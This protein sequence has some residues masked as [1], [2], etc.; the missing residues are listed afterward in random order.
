MAIGAPLGGI[1]TQYAGWQLMIYVCI[2]IALIGFVISW[3]AIPKEERLQSKEKFDYIGSFTFTASIILIM[4]FLTAGSS[5]GWGA[6]NTS[7][8][9]NG[10]L[11]SLEIFLIVEK[12]TQNAVYSISFVF[13]PCF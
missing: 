10:S 13:L 8:I 5:Q 4:L 6:L 3:I 2:P 12:Y 1:L 11:L 9:L 7:L